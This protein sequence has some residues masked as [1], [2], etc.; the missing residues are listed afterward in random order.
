MDL[1]EYKLDSEAAIVHV[2]AAKLTI[3]E[4]KHET[5]SVDYM[6]KVKPGNA[7]AALQMESDIVL[8]NS[9]AEK[10]PLS[11]ALQPSGLKK[12]RR[13]TAWPSNVA[14]A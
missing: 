12:A 4:D 8:K 3:A 9:K 13:L 6:C 1:L 10:R 14:T 2:S 11:D 7:H 5:C